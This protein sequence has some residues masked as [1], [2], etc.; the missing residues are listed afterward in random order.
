MKK[1][2]PFFFISLAIFG[3]VI[4]LWGCNDNLSDSAVNPQTGIGGSMAR[5]AITGNTLYIVSKQSLEVYNITDAANP[6]KA[7]TKDMSVGIETIFPYQ[8]RLFIGA[9]DGMYIYNNS[10]P[11]N[12]SFLTKYTHIQSCDPVVVQGNYAY[13]TLRGGV[14]CRNWVTQSTLDVVDVSDPSNPQ[15]VNSQIMQSPYGLGV[16]GNK[17][18]V[19]E[20]DNGFKILDVTDP[21]LPIVKQHFKELTSYDV[22]ARNNQ[23]IITGTKGLFQYKF[24]DQDEVELLSKIPVL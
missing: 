18:F 7:V 24:N 5:F 17:L 11:D 12:P 2:A 14:A 6:V 22:I 9:N 10:A 15:L 23:L 4:L 19:C 16:S 3:L 13:V 20:G 1:L 8:N 21:Q